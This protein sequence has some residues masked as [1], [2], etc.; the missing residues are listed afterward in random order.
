MFGAGYVIASG[1]AGDSLG[2]VCSLLQAELLAEA[3]ASSTALQL[4]CGL[5][6]EDGLVTSS[7]VH[8]T[9]SVGLGKAMFC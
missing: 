9:F 6:R 7:C 5:S 3:R 4:Y 1:E 8:S 2:R